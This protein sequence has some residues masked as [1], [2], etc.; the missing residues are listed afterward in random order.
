MDTKYTEEKQYLAAKKRIKEIKGFYAHLFVNV[1][2][3]IIIVAVNL[4]FS[5]YY[6]WFW[7]AVAGIC[8]AT[9]IHWMLVF[10][11]EIFGFGKDWEDKKIKEYLEKKK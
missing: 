10:G 4:I 3:I 8:I 6:H 2:S 11:K 7:F 1:L 5:P 9:F